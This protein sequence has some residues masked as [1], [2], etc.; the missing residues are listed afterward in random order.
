MTCFVRRVSKTK[1]FKKFFLFFNYLK[2]KRS[3]IKCID[4]LNGVID[5]G[6]WKYLD[7][8]EALQQNKVY[9]IVVDT[10][11]ECQDISMLTSRLRDQ[12]KWTLPNILV[13]TAPFKELSK[14]DIKELKEQWKK[15]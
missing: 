11:R 4:E 1:V 15:K 9:N 7:R 2:S 14:E 10:G 3:L 12:I 8:I 6:S 13:T 5:R